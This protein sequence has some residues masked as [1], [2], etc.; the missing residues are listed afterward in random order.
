MIDFA[1]EQAKVYS[2]TPVFVMDV[3]DSNGLHV[4]EIGCFHSAG[5]YA[6]D[7]EKVIHDV[8]KFIEDYSTVV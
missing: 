6:T 7:V 3:G 4:I 5:F 8:S 1:E 2:P